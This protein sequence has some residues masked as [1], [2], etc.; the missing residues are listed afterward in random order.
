M[1]DAEFTHEGDNCSFE[2][3]SNLL[4]RTD[5]ALR[6]IAQIVHDIDLKDNKFAREETAGI[7]HV[8]AGICASQKR[9]MDRIARGGT[10]L[11]DIYERF[12][13]GGSVRRSVRLT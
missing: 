2:V 4:T 8:M 3:L 9:D 11:D 10:V 6:A 12:R 13:Q 7:A 5:P 1:F